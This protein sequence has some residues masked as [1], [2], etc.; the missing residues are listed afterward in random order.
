MQWARRNLF[1]FYALIAGD[2]Y[3]SNLGIEPRRERSVFG[4]WAPE[5][6]PGTA[7]IDYLTGPI[8]RAYFIR[9][10]PCFARTDA[11]VGP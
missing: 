11:D 9:Y 4:P 6:A 3:Q 10:L 2:G 5:D 1:T 8:P 7:N